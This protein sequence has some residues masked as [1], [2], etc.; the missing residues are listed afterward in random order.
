MDSPFP[1]VALVV[2]IFIVV[3]V[4]VRCDINAAL[5]APPHASPAQ[6]EAGT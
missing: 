4:L 2:A 1:W 3:Q 6:V 5:S